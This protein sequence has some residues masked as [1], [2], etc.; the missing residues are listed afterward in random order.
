MTQTQRATQINYSMK[1]SA[2]CAP[3]LAE[4][5]RAPIRRRHQSCRRSET[6]IQPAGS[7][8]AR[9]DEVLRLVAEGYTSYQIALHLNLTE[10]TIENYRSKLNAIAGSINTVGMLRFF[11]QFTRLEAER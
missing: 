2:S 5:R 1:L 8:T 10:R 3:S 9:E 11:Y 7:L 6:K 4:E